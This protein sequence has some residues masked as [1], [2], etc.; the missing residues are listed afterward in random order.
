MHY[1]TRY[2]TVS[3]DGR[4]I[5][6]RDAGAKTAPTLFLLHGFPSSSRMFE[7]LLQRLSHRYRLVAPDYPGF[8]HS[9]WP[10]PRSFAYTFDHV[11]QIMT[12]LTDALG[13]QR[14][15]LYLQDYGGP[16]GFRMAMNRPD[17]LDGLV[18]QNA[19]AHAE[20]LGAS[21][22]VRRAFWEDRASHEA[23]LR[24]NLLSRAT[25]RLRHVG[26]D[27][28]V[29]LYDPD[30]W[31]D[32]MAFLSQPMQSEIQTD[33]FYDYRS[34]VV[35][36]PTWQ[37]WLRRTRPRLLVLWGKY[38]PSFRLVETEAY[39]H[40]VPNA[41][42]HVLEAGHF[43]LDTAANE[44]AALVAKFMDASRSGAS[45]TSAHGKRSAE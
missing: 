4:S 5:F 8:G 11:A 42:I 34:N 14:Y 36:Y 40:D 2:G 17:R 32:E 21:W 16:I 26:T 22:V 39:G 20:G 31:T 25:T 6:Y 45:S 35:A 12:A 33:L 23:A 43:A 41:E 30:L 13:L 1:P 29:D 3:I 15:T 38:D 28:N 9:D 24:E 27:P 37:D 7:P 10:D 19:V 44:I 18:I